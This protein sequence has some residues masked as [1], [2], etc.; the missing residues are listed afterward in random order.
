M[1]DCCGTFTAVTDDDSIS[2]VD[3]V[4]KVLHYAPF[5][6]LSIDEIDSL[7][8]KMRNAPKVTGLTGK[9][10][11][12]VNPDDDLLVRLILGIPHHQETD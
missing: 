3:I 6:D 11:K 10:Y 5:E 4:E 2:R 12:E 8:T 1:K 9:Y 7:N